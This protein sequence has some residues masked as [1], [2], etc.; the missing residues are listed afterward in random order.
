ML[1]E[2]AG[3]R[4]RFLNFLALG[5]FS[6]LNIESPKDLFKKWVISADI[7]H[8]RKL[9]GDNL[10]TQH[11]TSTFSGSCRGVITCPVAPGKLRSTLGREEK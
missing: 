11:Y 10:K 3:P 1:S 5:T 7:Y 2:N 6:L 9:N 8:I 4:Q